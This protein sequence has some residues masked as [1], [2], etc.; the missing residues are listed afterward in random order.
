MENVLYNMAQVLGITIIH[1]LWQGL[2]IY[3]VLRLALM[4]GNQLSASKKYLL[5][6]TSLAAVTAWFVYTL[7][8][9]IIIYNWLAVAPAKLSSLPLM[10]A[11]PAGIHQFNDQ[12]IRY[13]Y[14]IENYLPY[15]TLIYVAGLLFNI[16]RL[17]IGRRKINTIRR[18][19]SI[20]FKLQYQMDKF[21]EMLNIPYKVRVGLS[22]MVDVPCMVGYFKPVILLPFTLATYLGAEEI[23]AI[24]LHELAHIKRNDYLVNLLQQVIT[25]LLFFNP[26]A[27]LI[28]RIINEERENSC[29]DLVVNTYPNPIVYAKALLKLEQTRENNMRMAM[30][31]TGRKYQLLS[32]IERIMKNKKPT[33]SVRPALLAMLILT[34]GIGC[35]ALLNPQIAQGKISVKA[36]IPAFTQL[37]TD[38]GKKTVV[39]KSN[40]VAQKSKKATHVTSHENVVYTENAMSDDKGQEISA[41]MQK[42]SQQMQQYYNSDD[43]K[44]TQRQMEETGQKMQALYNNPELKKMQEEM[45]KLSTS[46]QKD[47]GNNNDDKANQ[48]SSK[49]G[50]R[51]RQIGAYYQS[52]EFKKMNAEL[53]KKYNL[54]AG[55]IYFNGQN[56]DENHKKYQAE[57]ETRIP[58]NIKLKQDELKELGEQMKK[59]YD[60]PEFKAQQERMRILS[61][62]M[63]VA[64]DSPKM[65]EDQKEMERLS[66][67]MAQ[68]QNNPQI[69]EAQKHM[70]EAA[71]KLSAYYSSPQ[72]KAYLHKLKSYTYKYNYNFNDNVARPEKPEVPE[73]PEAPEQ[74]EIQAPTQPVTPPAPPAF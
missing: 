38:T 41:E 60:S 13:Y 4:M 35:I 14:S 73:K 51:G 70:Q 55:D 19:M 33:Q 10:L 36:I 21:T 72:Y 50:E 59:R 27:Q 48:L 15:I 49:M 39:K 43:F 54:P 69:K 42:Y 22:K 45:Q 24:L 30:Q 40:P 12:S 32:R 26:C 71:K 23:E 37:L 56:E 31:A 5:A 61:D 17:I 66:E 44:A 62:S 25:M 8:N 7:T 47:W 46:F 53:R 9:E 58:A 2:F 57:L 11:L 74:P 52:P 28:N 64:Y 65:K 63:H 68:Y 20:D 6:L 34:I 18:T 16:S 3:F 29:D 1:S 67:K